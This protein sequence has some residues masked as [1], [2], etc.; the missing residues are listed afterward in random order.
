MEEETSGL[1]GLR[2]IF[3][4]VHFDVHI[5][6]LFYLEVA[7]VYGWERHGLGFCGPN[8]LPCL[9]HMDLGGFNGLCVVA[10]DVFNCEEGPFNV[11]AGAYGLHPRGFYWVPADGVNPLDPLCNGW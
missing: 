3:C 11:V 9:I 7:R 8:I 5:M 6:C 1:V 4:F 2:G 10:V